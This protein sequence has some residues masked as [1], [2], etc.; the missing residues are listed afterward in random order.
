MASSSAAAAAATD[1][2]GARNS[3]HTV[4]VILRNAEQYHLWRARVSAACWA[5][6]RANVFAISDDECDAANEAYNKGDTKLDLVG[7]CWSIITNALHDDLFI[8]LSHVKQG[9]IASLIEEIRLALLV[10]IAEDVQPLR[11]ELYAATMTA[12]N[13]DLQSYISYLV[14][15]RDKLRFL[16]V[17]VPDVEM[18]HV[19]LKGLHPTFQPLQVYFAIPGAL[20]DTFDKA[21]D[22]VRRFAATP[23]VH[24]ELIKLKGAS[25]SQTVFAA[26]AKEK[27]LCK[28]YATSGSCTFG[29]SCKFVHSNYGGA[30]AKPTDS[31]SSVTTPKRNVKCN[32]CKRRGHTEDICRS[33]N[34]NGAKPVSLVAELSSDYA[35]DQTSENASSEQFIFVLTTEYDHAVCS[36]SLSVLPCNGDPSSSNEADALV[37]NSLHQRPPR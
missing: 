9:H 34:N 5:A 24:G 21:V 8:K 10:N 32:F 30:S 3:N 11:L 27:A 1:A 6:T 17:K 7:K 19:F 29:D 26:V 13:S 16:E 33:K 23:V 35:E 22:I 20:P 4:K 25:I 14:Q 12:C 15:R 28:K 37:L 36:D 31:R 18:V 2:D